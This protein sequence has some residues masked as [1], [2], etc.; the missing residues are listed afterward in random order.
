MSM[1]TVGIE[2]IFAYPGALTLDMVALAEARGVSPSHPLEDLWV[3]SRSLN[4]VWED[5]VSMAVNAARGLLE[6]EDPEQV[7]LVVVGTES[8]VDY[9]KP[10]SSW[11]QRLAGIGPNCRNFETKHA[12]YGGTGGLMAAAHWIASGFNR[13]KKALVV[14]SDQS[15]MHLGKPW[16]FVLG[17]A[18]TA[19]LLSD[20]P[21]L[22]EFELDKNGYWTHEISDT[23]RPTSRD[24][25]GHADTSLFGYLEAVEGACEHFMEVSGEQDYDGNFARHVYHV[26]FG[27]MTYRAHR[28]VMRRWAPGRS[29]KELRAHFE[30]KSKAGLK[31]NRRLG[32]TYTS[33]TF[34]ALMGTISAGEDLRGGDRISVFSYGSGSCSEF[35]PVRVGDRAR[36]IVAA[37]DLDGQLDARVRVSVPEYEAIEQAR[38]TYVDN[39][40]YETDKRGPDGAWAKHWDARY[41]G[42]GLCVLDGVDNWERRYRLS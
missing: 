25:V 38:A 22:L 37:A 28:A 8:S 10:I 34:L 41:E 30:R 17:G 12:C 14:C 33:A 7:E 2:K 21:E 40:T 24:E 4:P 6:G 13:G 19:M 20:K 15:R 29:N 36:E 16:E 27:A 23:Y 18:A 3:E 35:Y 5:P 42:R 31:Y 39:P 11:V 26:P 9:G 32:G 1:N